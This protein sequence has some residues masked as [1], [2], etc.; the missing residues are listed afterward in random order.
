MAEFTGVPFV[1]PPRRQQGPYAKRFMV[2]HC[3]A[4]PTSNAW[5][6]ANYARDRTDGVGLHF[7]SDDARVVQTTAT[8]M[9]VGHVGSGTGN[10]HGICW[11]FCATLATSTDWYKRLIDVAA[12]TMRAAM[13]KHG[14]PARWLTQSQA[15]DGS[16]KGLLTHDDCRR[17]FGGTTHTDPGPNFPRQ[18][19]I[20]S[21]TSVGT[22]GAGA[23]PEG[24]NMSVMIASVGGTDKAYAG[25]GLGYW[26]LNGDSAS[27]AWQAASNGGHLWNF[28]NMAAMRQVFGPT[29]YASQAEAIQDWRRVTATATVDPIVLRDA[30]AAALQTPEAR[31]AIVA[32]VNEAEDS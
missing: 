25:N 12:P 16:S 8:I 30:V 9:S 24:V 4:N 1:G 23:A 3:T 19:L 22:T 20:D 29:E 14:I 27:Q 2:V 13:A 6:E 28:A 5:G 21:L 10:R 31:A 26:W 7:A 32:A 17:W 18:Y 11:E 15:L